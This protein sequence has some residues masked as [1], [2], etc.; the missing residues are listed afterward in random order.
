MFHVLMLFQKH[1]SVWQAIGLIAGIWWYHH[2]WFSLLSCYSRLVSV[3]TSCTCGGATRSLEV[4]SCGTVAAVWSNDF[5]CMSHLW[6]WHAGNSVAHFIGSLICLIF[7]WWALLPSAQGQWIAFQLCSA[8]P[9]CSLFQYILKL[10][11]S[12]FVHF[13]RFGISG[14]DEV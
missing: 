13:T 6:G 3:Q 2:K 7:C 4:L 11:L 9:Y 1:F 8:V 10:T 5:I 12:L 14:Y